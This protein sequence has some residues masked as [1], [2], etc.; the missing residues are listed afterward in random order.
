MDRVLAQVHLADEVKRVQEERLKV[1]Q[2]LRRL[3]DVYL[4]GLRT[5]DDY[6]REKR[7]LEG[8]ARFPGGPGCRRRPRGRE[9]SGGPPLA[10][11]PG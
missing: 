4:D 11:G 5:R 7:A 2:R 8:Q 6:L 3:G 9:A 10:M 1:E